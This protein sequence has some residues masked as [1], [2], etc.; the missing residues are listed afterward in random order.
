MLARTIAIVA[1][2]WWF[3]LF[4]AVVMLVIA[5]ITDA[6]FVKSGNGVVSTM[7]WLIFARFIHRSALFGIRFGEA[8]PDGSPDRSYG[9]FMFKGLALLIVSL[10]VAAPALFWAM[11]S[12]GTASAAPDLRDVYPFLVAL[13]V[14]YALVLSL[15]GSW[16]PASVYRQN[17]GLGAALKRGYRTFSMCFYGLLRR[18]CLRSSPSSQR[19]WRSCYSVSIRRSS[20]TARSIPPVASARLWRSSSNPSA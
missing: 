16:L 20:A 13:P 19:F 10:I 1:A 4:F 2:N 3:Y 11:G 17:M 12:T 5:G 6:G 18:C 7:L 15:V 8:N 9:G 14:A